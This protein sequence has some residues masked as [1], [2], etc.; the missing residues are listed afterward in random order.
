MG[1]LSYMRCVVDRNVVMWRIPVLQR[2]T[3]HF[4]E[5]GGSLKAVFKRDRNL[6]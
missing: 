6:F 4:T 3:P 5:P 1:P 2:K